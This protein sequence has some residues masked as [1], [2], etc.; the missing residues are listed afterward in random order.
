M[1]TGDFLFKGTIG[2]TDLETG[3]III[4]KNS[5]EKIKKYSDNIEIYPGH[6]NKTT[7][8]YE[9]KHNLYLLE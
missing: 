3:N 7:L 2:R 4:M 1:F 8:E 6:G 5:I 9:K